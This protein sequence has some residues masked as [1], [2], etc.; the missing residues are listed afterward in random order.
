MFDERLSVGRRA[1]FIIALFCLPLFINLGANS[2]WDGNEGFFAEPPRELLETGNYLIPTYNYEP[3]FKKPPFTSW[4]IAASYSIFGVSEFAERLPAAIAAVLLIFFIYKTGRDFVNSRVGLAAALI[5]ATMLKFMIYSRQFAGEIFITLVTTISIVY[6]ARAM[7][8]DDQNKQLPNK[9]IAYT[10]IGFGV[11]IKGPA[12]VIPLAVVG[13][14]ILLIRRWDLLKLFFSPTGYLIVLSLGMSWYLMM[15]YKFGWT[16]IKVN[17]IQEAV[18]RFTTDELGQRPFHYFFGVYF[19]ETLPWSIF[20]VP[21]MVYWFKWLRRELWRLPKIDIRACW[22]ILTL[23]WFIF[24]FIFF[25]ISVGKRANYI[26]ILYPA[27]ALMIGQYF[28]QQLFENDRLIRGLH[29]IMTLLLTVVCLVGA[30]I[31]LLAYQQLEIRTVL[32]YLP[33]LMMLLLSSGICWLWYKGNWAA[34]SRIIAIAGLGLI[35]SITLILPKIEY[36]RP[37]PRFA[38]IIKQQAN[39]KDEIGTF[40]VDT[41][42]LM[43]YAER[44]IFQS[45]NFEEMLERLDKEPQVYFITREDYLAMLQARTTIPLNVVASQPLLQLRWSNF[46]GRSSQPTQK[47][48][49]VKKAN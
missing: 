44:K 12:V 27:A 4:I 24:V 16:F 47:L 18:G 14:F 49:L 30:A 25:S 15:F 17:I 39:V 42:S 3:R 48:V 19:A 41:P 43:F 8:D 21:A 31:I 11:L 6:F 28:C 10:A 1:F 38:E 40:F 9:L 13:I 22:P 37:I 26:I 45:A 33:I 46:I 29:K 23:I 7:L 5:L 2:L 35:F 32:I 34:Q 36:Y 20:I